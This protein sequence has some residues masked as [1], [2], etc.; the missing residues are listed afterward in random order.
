ML[1]AFNHLPALVY[2]FNECLQVWRLYC[3]RCG[4]HG[5]GFPGDARTVPFTAKFF[6]PDNFKVH[7]L[8]IL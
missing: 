6:V 8:T 3:A 2:Y 5:S 7:S 1:R 4:G